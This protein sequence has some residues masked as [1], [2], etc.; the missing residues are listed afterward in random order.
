MAC[1]GMR[2]M[3]HMQGSAA[4]LSLV[5]GNFTD[6]RVVFLLIPSSKVIRISQ[7]VI[8]Q[9]ARCV[10]ICVRRVGVLYVWDHGTRH[11]SSYKLSLGSDRVRRPAG[12]YSDQQRAR[13]RRRP[14][15]LACLLACSVM[16]MVNKKRNRSTMH[17]GKWLRLP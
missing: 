9:L 6:S 11:A 16:A 7:F 15:S 1:V 12:L 17:R 14:C 13:D 10:C 2:W 4:T 5:V 8:T 3:P